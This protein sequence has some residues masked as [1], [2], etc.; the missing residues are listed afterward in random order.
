M[1][2]P[3]R[4]AAYE[5]LRSIDAGR[6][7]LPHALARAREKLPD[8]RDRALAAEIAAG[9][10]RL[11]GAFDHVIAGFAG[12]KLDRLDREIIIILRLTMFQLLQLERVPASAA[13]NDAVSLARRAGKRS[14]APLVNAVLRR[15]SRERRRLPLPDRPGPEGSAGARLDYLSVTLSHPRWL[16][17]RWMRRHGFEAA[18]AWARFD[19]QSAPL[20][21]RASRLRTTPE[22]LANALAVHGVLAVPGRFAPDALVVTSG[23]PLL[24]PLAAEGLFVVQE[25]AS[26]I[27]PFMT[28]VQPGER[29]LDACASPGGK[30]TALAAMMGDRGLI[31]AGDVRPGRVDLLARTVRMSG[32][33]SIRVLRADAA[34]PLPFRGVFDCVLLDAPCSGLGTL[35]R[36]PD[37]RWRRREDEFAPLAGLQLRLL[38]QTSQALRPGGRLVYATC[39]GEPEENEDVVNAFLARGDFVARAPRNLPRTVEGLVNESGHLRTY[40]FRDGVEAFFAAILVKG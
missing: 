2:A 29:V 14:A 39:S 1:I 10:L 25:E 6:A 37:L 27:V 31:V 35:R 19:N 28:G 36:D 7:D 38:E 26:Q 4:V 16:V 3:A 21:I 18:E 32:A 24:T 17:A 15:V 30:A 5:I 9:T 40:P 33:H 20:T 13:V 22:D 12:R 23:N 34:A 11:Q 8:A